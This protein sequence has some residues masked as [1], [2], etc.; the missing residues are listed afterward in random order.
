MLWVDHQ[1][2]AYLHYKPHA[3][4][5]TRLWRGYSTAVSEPFG[6]L[7]GPAVVTCVKRA[8][9]RMV[10]HRFE[11]ST[12]HSYVRSSPGLTAHAYHSYVRSSPGLTAHTRHSYVPVHTGTYCARISQLRSGPHRDLLHTYTSQLRSG[13]HRDLLHTH[14]TATFLSSPGLTAHVCHS[15]VLVLTGTYYT[16]TSHLRSGPHRDLLHT[17]HSYVPV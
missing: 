9:A 3:S 11:S 5:E 8:P 6:V 17:Y 14:I 10:Q 2:G 15:Y 7:W 12:R 1:K 4:H 13:T 16:R